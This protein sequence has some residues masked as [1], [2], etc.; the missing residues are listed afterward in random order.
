MSPGDPYQSL[1]GGHIHVGSSISLRNAESATRVTVRALI[2]CLEDA[3]VV[4]D[5]IIREG[6]GGEISL[7][8]D[9]GLSNA[10]RNYF[11][12]GSVSGTEPGLPLP[13]GQVTLPLNW[14]LFTGITYKYANT[15]ILLDFYGTLD[16]SGQSAALLNTYG[17]LPT[18][19]AGATMHFAYLLYPPFDFASGPVGITI[20]P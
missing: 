8:L 12:L 19:S 18:G 11:V 5:R 10:N 6:E 20:V 17:P 9:A 4:N 2:D 16:G 3:L 7:S 13:G 1:A 14:D 15:P